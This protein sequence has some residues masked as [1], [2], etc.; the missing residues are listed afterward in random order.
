M[1]EG[2]HHGYYDEY[3]NYSNINV[4]LKFKSKGSSGWGLFLFLAKVDEHNMD[5]LDDF[6]DDYDYSDEI[7]RDVNIEAKKIIISPMY[8]IKWNNDRKGFLF[9]R[10]IWSLS[11]NAEV[12]SNFGVGIVYLKKTI[13]NNLTS[14][15]SEEV[16]YSILPKID[17]LSAKIGKTHCFNF[18]IGIG[19]GYFGVYNL[20]YSYR[21]NI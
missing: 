18:E 5:V 16:E 21:F 8:Y 17:M 20:G 13:Y 9:G 3:L 14:E 4:N 7:T 11:P 12:S 6:W 15:I 1:I 2:S 10:R 19:W